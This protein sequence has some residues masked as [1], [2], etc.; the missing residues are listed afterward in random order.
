MPD[1]SF[2]AADDLDLRAVRF[3]TAVAEARH[4]GRAAAQ[5]HVAQPYLSR[6]IRGLEQRIGARLLDRGPQGTTL[7]EA[8]EAYLPRA[9][10]L[11]GL[12]A[13]ARAAAL[14]AARPSR[15]TIGRTRSIHIDAAVNELRRVHPDAEVHLV[16]LDW[17]EP[18]EALLERRV[19]AVVARFP[20]ATESLDVAVLYDEPRELLV[21]LHHRLAGKEQVTLEDIAD[22]P[23][24]KL[25][26]PA[27]NAFWRIDPRPDGTHA[28]DGPTVEVLEDKLELVAAGQAVAIVAAGFRGIRPDLTTVPLADVEPSHVLLATRTGDRS[29]LV[30]A[31]RKYARRYLTGPPATALTTEVGDP[32]LSDCI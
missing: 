29:R 6:Q 3:F 14:A 15:I 22:E 30:D 16:D 23:L 9:K 7:T 5:L 4:F 25:P 21:P 18:R 12:A 13:K 20:L 8:G 19:D 26:D 17:N 24:P 28:P 10:A 11:L 32:R 31:F 2:S 1:K 27:W